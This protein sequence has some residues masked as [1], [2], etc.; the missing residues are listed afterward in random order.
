[1][2]TKRAIVTP[3]KHF[4]LADYA[5]INVVCKAID[6]VKPNIYIDLGDVGEFEGASHWKWSKRKRPPLEYMLPSI[7]KDIK[8]VND[9]MDIIDE[10][11]YKINCKNKH[12]TEGNHDDW[13]NQFVLQHPYLKEVKFS[14]KFY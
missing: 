12:I 2:V 6:L 4:P 3:D 5:A 13:C 11:L 7:E 9:G 10:A 1:M 8:D 14:I